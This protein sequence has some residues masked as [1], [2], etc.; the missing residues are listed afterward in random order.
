MAL[1]ISP[2]IKRSRAQKPKRLLRGLI[3]LGI[4]APDAHQPDN[5]AG[6]TENFPGINAPHDTKFGQELRRTIRI[7]TRINQYNRTPHGRHHGRNSWPMDSRQG[8]QFKRGGHDH[9]AGITRRYGRI[10][11]T[12]ID[13]IHHP[14]DG[15]ILF[16]ANS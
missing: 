4:L 9:R 1:N 3:P 14:T 16:L 10:H 6:L 2:E 7:C 15:I 13:H 8:P 11:L 12:R 5:W